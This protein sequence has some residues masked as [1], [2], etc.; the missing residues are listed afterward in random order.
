MIVG[1]ARPPTPDGFARQTPRLISY[2]LEGED[3][4]VP[5]A[6][7]M[8]HLMI[9]THTL[10]CLCDQGSL[11]AAEKEVGEFESSAPWQQYVW[12]FPWL[13]SSG[14]VSP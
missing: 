13:G 9:R 6:N 4:K 10:Q 14:D 8:V 12:L 5:V 3:W 11:E 2:G 1:K 7:T